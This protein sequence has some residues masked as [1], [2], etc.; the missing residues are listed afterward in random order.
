MAPRHRS[1][2]PRPAPAPAARKAP[3]DTVSL[4]MV[5]GLVLLV[6]QILLLG[7]LS[8]WPAPP[9]ELIPGVAL[10]DRDAP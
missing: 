3:V 4:L 10:R 8:T 1:L 7:V 5:L 2:A 9:W 6:G